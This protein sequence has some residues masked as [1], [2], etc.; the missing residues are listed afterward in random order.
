MAEFPDLMN[1]N[2]LLWASDYP[3]SDSTWPDSMPVLAKTS[4]GI[5]TALLKKIVHTN[6]RD[7]FKLDLD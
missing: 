5:D 4:D 1:A 2:T 3:H 6:T 7:L